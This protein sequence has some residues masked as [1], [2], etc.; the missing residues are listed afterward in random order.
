V[1]HAPVLV[2]LTDVHV[3]FAG[4][5]SVEVLRG[6]HLKVLAGESVAIVGPSGSGKSTLLHLI[7][8]LLSPTGG[9][10]RI[11]GAD[12]SQMNERELAEL[13]NRRIGIVFQS[14]HLL[15][16]C[17]ALEN[18]LVPVLAFRARASAE[19]VAR[20][21]HLLDVVG[22]SDRVDHPPAQLSGGE[23]QR[24]AVARA[25]MQKPLVLLAD[26]PTGSLDQEGASA[27]AELLQRLNREESVTMVVVTHSES[28]AR[29]MK[30]VLELRH[31]ML[32]PREGRP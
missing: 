21:R 28:L 8:A 27:L 15:P 26:E 5:L 23:C 30:R 6:V 19:E 4:P 9:S 31:G 18:V 11:Q 7:G 25:L 29:G 32:H 1:N 3:R 20:A 12:L 24:V 17:T 22:L 16:Q 14:H 13:R 10:V 2:E